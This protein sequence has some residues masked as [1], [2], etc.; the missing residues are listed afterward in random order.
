MG[1]RTTYDYEYTVRL[2]EWDGGGPGT[3]MG[4]FPLQPSLCEWGAAQ[5]M[6]TQQGRKKGRGE[7]K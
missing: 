7:E 6:K 3:R 1:R 4:I 5:N 2:K